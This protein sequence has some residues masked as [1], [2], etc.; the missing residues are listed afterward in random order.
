MTN[1]SGILGYKKGIVI[2]SPK[3]LNKNSNELMTNYFPLIPLIN[4]DFYQRK[5]AKSA[6]DKQCCHR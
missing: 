5:S 1:N 3:F 4:A 2:V 6:G